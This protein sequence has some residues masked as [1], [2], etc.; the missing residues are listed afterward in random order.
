MSACTAEPDAVLGNSDEMG[1]A[2]E[3]SRRA[4]I[5]SPGDIMADGFN[6]FD[7]R[8]YVSPTPTAVG[9][10]A[11]EMGEKGAPEILERLKGRRFRQRA[12]V[13][14]VAQETV[15]NNRYRDPP[16]ARL[17]KAVGMPFKRRRCEP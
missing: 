16:P 10:P 13:P 5:E 11:Y 7:L 3:V 14:D 4:E 6:A 2:A 9:S 17:L 15:E 1:I 12:I 8:H